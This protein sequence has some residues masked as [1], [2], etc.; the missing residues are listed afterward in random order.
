L[1]NTVH[2][3]VERYETL[4]SWLTLQIDG[5]EEVTEVV[6]L[7]LVDTAGVNDPPGVA[8]EGRIEI[9][10]VNDWAAPALG[11]PETWRPTIAAR[12]VKAKTR[13]PTIAPRRPG[14]TWRREGAWLIGSLVLTLPDSSYR[15]NSMGPK[16]EELLDH[17]VAAELS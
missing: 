10:G 6:P 11:L 14:R 15:A 12:P 7:L 3:P 4:P 5:V 8:D 2:V 17:K 13:V 16:L 9:V 1:L